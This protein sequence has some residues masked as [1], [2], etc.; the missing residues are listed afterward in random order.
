[1]L[2]LTG[3]VL[4]IAG[5][6]GIAAVICR[7]YNSRLDTLMVIR[8][9]YEEFKYY[10]SYQ[11]LTV[12]E[13]LLRLSEKERML[14]SGEFYEIYETVHNGAGNFPETW[15]SQIGK[16]LAHTTLNEKE[17]KLLLNFP[18]C[19]GYMEGG[20]QTG[21]LEELQR[22]TVNCIEELSMEQKNKN[23]MVMSLGIAGGVLVSIL[24]L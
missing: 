15:E 18:S 11:K 20:G 12:P 3:C 9:I 7:D 24:L 8:D 17:K 16:A 13:T 4:I 1:M 22:Q 6:A 10:I 5:C 23:K 2:Q 14:F 19:L 21:A